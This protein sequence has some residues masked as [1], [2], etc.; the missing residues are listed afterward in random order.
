[1]GGGGHR[2]C[3]YCPCREID[4]TM[5]RGWLGLCL[6]S[7]RR[8]LGGAIYLWIENEGGLEGCKGLSQVEKRVLLDRKAGFGWGGT[9]FCWTKKQG[10]DEWSKQNV[11]N[12]TLVASKCLER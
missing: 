10:F 9:W 2:V 7:I 8:K 4:T 11:T 12:S 5:K 6:F 1:M 3:K